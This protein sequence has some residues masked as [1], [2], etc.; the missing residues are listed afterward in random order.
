LKFLYSGKKRVW[1]DNPKKRK[2][3]HQKVIKKVIIFDEN[4]LSAAE[5]VIIE[6]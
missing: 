1:C 3:Q 4:G 5:K 6:Y 2:C